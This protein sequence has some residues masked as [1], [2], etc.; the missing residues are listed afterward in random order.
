MP[1]HAYDIPDITL[2]PARRLLIT[3]GLLTVLLIWAGYRTLSVD[4]ALH[5]H[6][7]DAVLW[8]VLFL[9][10]AQQF[11]VAWF[12][13]PVTVTPAEQSALDQLVVTVCIPVLNEDPA[14]LDRVLY[15]LFSQT[16]LPDYVQVVDDGSDSA[17]YSQ[18]REYWEQRH[19]AQVRFSWVRFPGNRGKRSAQ[20][21]TFGQLPGDIFVTLDSDTTLERRAI[22]EGLKPFTSPRVMSVAGVEVAMNAHRNLLTRV[23]SLRQIAWQYTQCSALSVRGCVLVSRGTFA[24]YRAGVIR[25]NLPAYLSETFLGRPVS[26]SDDS[27]LTLY[28]LSRGRAVQQPTAFQLPVYPEKVGHALRQWVR[29]MRGST[30]RN[31]WRLRY[32]P[33]RSYGWWMSLLGWWQFFLSTS[34]Y[35]LVFAIWP[36]E[37]R[38]SIIPV[39]IIILSSYLIAQRNLLIS[40]SDQPAESQLDTYLLAPLCML[41][42]MLVLRPLRLYAML[43]CAKTSWAT[44]AT[45]EIELAGPGTAAK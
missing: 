21:A 37:G 22:E 35:V 18:I 31:F 10:T 13:R 26:F 7:A 8:T 6:D 19:P 40:R 24:L 1:E 32:L 15:A 23:S 4:R 20:A 3:A 42:S 5:G 43:T 16:R 12:D 2:R 28:A 9:I 34:A 33:L 27:L 30:I 36:V 14:I 29:W 44:R 17:D 38:A 45:V 25:D 41:W 39:M 11:V